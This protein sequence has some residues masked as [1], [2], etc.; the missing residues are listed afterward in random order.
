MK[1]SKFIRATNPD[2]AALFKLPLPPPLYVPEL[3]VLHD[4]A[5]ALRPG[6]SKKN[7]IEIVWV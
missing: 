4:V 1:G 7:E 6:A 5:P 2:T 3:Q